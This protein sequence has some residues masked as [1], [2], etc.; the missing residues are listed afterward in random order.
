NVTKTI[1]PARIKWRATLTQA[2]DGLP[3]T[4]NADCSD[5]DK[6][7][8]PKEDGYVGAFEGARYFHC[9]CYRPAFNCRMRVLGQSFCGVC[10]QVMGD[11]LQ[12]FLPPPPATAALPS[13]TN[14]QPATG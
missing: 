9:G 10:Q 3:T 4:K 13:G 7:A 1:D 8:N 14:V 5:C 11:V 2:D 6:Q 12:P